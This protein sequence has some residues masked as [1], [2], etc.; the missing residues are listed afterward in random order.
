MLNTEKSGQHLFGA[1]PVI[2]YTIDRDHRNAFDHCL[3]LL[4][5]Y[6]K[7][8]SEVGNEHEKFSN[9]VL[10]LRDAIDDFN[11]DENG[12]TDAD[13]LFIQRIMQRVGD[14]DKAAAYLERN[15]NDTFI[16]N[17]LDR[18][19]RHIYEM[20]CV[21]N[22]NDS[23]FGLQSN[24]VAM[25]YKLL[26][27]EY[28]VADMESYFTLGLYKRLK[29]IS[30]HKSEIIKEPEK[31][32]FVTIDCKRN[33]PED[34]ERISAMAVQLAG[35]K[36]I[37]SRESILELFPENLVPNKKEEIER[38]KAEQTLNPVLGSFE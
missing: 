15:V 12:L 11:K 7:L 25:A 28:M 24:I 31:S 19:E 8:I 2:E 10:M 22:P 32:N 37:L 20:L 21:F 27:L 17:T 33:L 3:P 1:V 16:N 35:G 6:D 23:N 18:L 38:I 34:I 29:I 5:Y 14:V 26:C 13:K 4:D 36:Q 9:S 30:Y